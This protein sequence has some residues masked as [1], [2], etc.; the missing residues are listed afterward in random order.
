MNVPGKS[1]SLLL[2]GM[3]R[4]GSKPEFYITKYCD[5][6]G[7]GHWKYESRN[8]LLMTDITLEGLVCFYLHAKNTHL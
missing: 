6:M 5:K 8:Y 3:I 2:L 4:E 1:K 7:Q